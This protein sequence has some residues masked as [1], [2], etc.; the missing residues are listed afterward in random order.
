[1]PRCRL[2]RPR[3]AHVDI[4]FAKDDEIVSLYQVRAFDDALQ[5]VCGHCWV[6]ALTRSEKG[7]VVIS[8][9]EVHAVDAEPVEAIV[10]TTGAGD[11]YAVGFLYGLTR[12]RGL[13]TCARC[14]GLASAEVIGH[15]GAC[16]ERLG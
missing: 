3:R 8:A 14:G 10:D 2:L 5:H 9:D 16:P 13:G 6:A 15:F 4:L 1:M 7:S 11:A 12:N